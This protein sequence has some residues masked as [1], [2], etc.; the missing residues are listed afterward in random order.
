MG[1]KRTG[2]ETVITIATGAAFGTAV[3]GGTTSKVFVNSFS[4]AKNPVILKENPIGGGAIMTGTD[5]QQ[6]A[7]SPSG[8]IAGDLH[9]NDAKLAAIFQ[10]FGGCSV[11]A[12]TG[13][14]CQSILMNE[15]A[16]QNFLTLAEAPTTTDVI[17]WPSATI[18]KITL[19]C[20]SFPGPVEISIDWLANNRVIT[21]TTNTTASMN[22]AAIANTLR[23]IAGNDDFFCLN[24]QASSALSTSTDVKAIQ[25]FVIT[26]E[27]SQ[28]H[29]FE[30]WG[31][32]GNTVPALDGNPPFTCTVQVE[33]RTMADLAYF[34]AMDAGTAYKAGL[35][36]TGPTLSGTNYQFNAFFP[37][38]KLLTD[39]KHDLSSPADNPLTLNFDC[40]Y[41]PSVPSGMIQR[42]PH[43]T[44]VNDRATPFTTTY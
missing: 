13:A 36:I 19:T 30:M 5:A 40:L 9:Y 43:F 33:L 37:Y 2:A 29:V 35:F 18:K 12:W 41:A 8:T 32:T 7:I 21:G 25:A 31:G 3:Q 16:N 26:Y 1:V 10:M 38:L 20:K 39:L 11:T 34:T 27:R 28:K 42:Y 24:T 44:I 15:T 14:N 23:V 17:E 4:E 6:G 22:A